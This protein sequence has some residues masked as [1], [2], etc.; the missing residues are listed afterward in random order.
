MHRNLK[1]LLIG[2]TSTL[3]AATLMTFGHPGTA[4]AKSTYTPKSLTVQFVPSSNASS[5]EAK[6]KPL[7]GLLQKQLHV[8]VKVSVSTN[9]N[10]IV[11]AMG[12]KKVDVGFLPPDGYVQAHKMN[13]AKVLL[14]ALRYGVD[15]PSGKNNKK[16]VNYYR[17]MILVKKNSGIK[18]LK[19]LKGKKIA[20][21][22]TTSTAG[23]IFPVAELAKHGVN[24]KKD[25]IKTVTVTGHD[26]G[27]M[28]V[29]NGNT[30]AAFVFADARQIVQKDVKDVFQTTKPL[31]LTNKI[32]ND[33]I[34]VRGD[35]SPKWQKKISRAFIKIGKS[36][37]GRKIIKSVYSHEGYAPAKDST[38]NIIRKY[39]KQ[40]KDAE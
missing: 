9:Y 4:S 3:A 2:L 7:E 38:F 31:Y 40:V 23:Y 36:K 32:P 14:Q 29:V 37:E 15:E 6:A 13:H 16:L 17:S 26:Q 18:S 33:T 5:I 8:P 28:S 20:V 22:D 19:D 25:N 21:Q 30:D 11:E 27:V 34:S 39:D 12:S 10:T 24:I 1:R 35:M